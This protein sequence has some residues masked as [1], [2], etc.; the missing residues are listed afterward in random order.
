MG[1][2]IDAHSRTSSSNAISF[3]DRSVNKLEFS[4]GVDLDKTSQETAFVLRQ[5][6]EGGNTMEEKNILNANA[7]L[8]GP[9]ETFRIRK[10]FH[11]TKG[12]KQ[13]EEN[14]CYKP[15]T[16]LVRDEEHWNNTFRIQGQRKKCDIN[17]VGSVLHHLC[18]L[19]TY[20]YFNSYLHFCTAS[21]I[22]L[23]LL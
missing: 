12:Q 2:S 9:V 6:P 5:A 17:L 21:D 16:S 23:P 13:G 18:R 1:N 4:H 10:P 20:G 3:S 22:I 11:S 15:R 19:F 7:I 14:S 8:E